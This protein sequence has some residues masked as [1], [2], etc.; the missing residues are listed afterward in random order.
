[1]REN[2]ITQDRMDLGGDS[3]SGEGY[4]RV[5]RQRYQQEDHCRMLAKKRIET[6]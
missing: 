6:R 2:G 5:R 3:S 1:M 4:G